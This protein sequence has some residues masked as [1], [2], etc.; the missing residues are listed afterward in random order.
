LDWRQI[1]AIHRIFL[2]YKSVYILTYNEQLK[3]CC[4]ILTWTDLHLMQILLISNSQKICLCSIPMII[5]FTFIYWT[6]LAFTLFHY[7][8]KTSAV[9]QHVIH[10]CRSVFFLFWWWI[11]F[12]EV[13]RLLSSYR[14]MS[15]GIGWDICKCV[16]VLSCLFVII[17]LLSTKQEHQAWIVLS[18]TYQA[19][20][21][22]WAKRSLSL[23]HKTL[24]SVKVGTS[25]SLSLSL[26]L[27][28]WRKTFCLYP[29]DQDYSTA[30][31]VSF[32]I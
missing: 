24:H 29:Y 1:D 25:L 12:C 17:Y 18:C 31:S 27:T 14:E 7:L 19:N 21:T 28:P 2:Q 15:F 8:C 23:S 6:T 30:S 11:D 26:S 5:Y 22:D 16:R 3:K 32:I 20:S 4:S 10:A 13:T 9:R